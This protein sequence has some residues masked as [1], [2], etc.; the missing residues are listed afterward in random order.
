MSD[1]GIERTLTLPEVDPRLGP[2]GYFQA[3]HGALAAAYDDLARRLNELLVEVNWTSNTL[4]QL[5]GDVN[6]YD[7]GTSVIHRLSSDAPRTITGFLAPV[8]ERTDILINVGTN[9]IVIPNQNVG[10]DTENRVITSTGGSIT[11][12]GN[13]S[14]MLWYDTTS[15]RFR[16]L[17]F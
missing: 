3:L 17:V 10:S 16:H 14:M 11:L 2:Q 8:I 15:S 7:L 4:P 5:T 12:A 6:N 13:A 9:N 1:S